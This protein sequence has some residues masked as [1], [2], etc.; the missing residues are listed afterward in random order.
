MSVLFQMFG[1]FSTCIWSATWI[2]V[3]QVPTISGCK[4]CN[5]KVERE[6][7]LIT[8]QGQILAKLG[9]KKPPDESKSASNVSRQVLQTYKSA[10]REKDKLLLETKICR[11]QI[12]TE[13][14]FAK[15][16]ERILLEKEVAR[17][18]VPSEYAMITLKL[19]Y[20]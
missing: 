2:N 20:I 1:I 10:V 8:V 15:R 14:F 5:S 18:A 9:L 13:E 17:T 3:V 4:L 11:S 19:I 12:D 7:R 6:K 16:V